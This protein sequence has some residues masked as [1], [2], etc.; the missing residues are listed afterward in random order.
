[1]G[2]DLIKRSDALSILEKVFDEYSMSFGED[3]GG[4]AEAVPK[5]IKA[6]PAVVKAGERN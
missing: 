5:A 1:M 3:R 4:F 6:I 2:E